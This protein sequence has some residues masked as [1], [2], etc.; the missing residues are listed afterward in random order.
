MF[1]PSCIIS[2][3]YIL[4][5]QVWT[6]VIKHSGK[7]KSRNIS[8]VSPLTGKVVQCAK[9]YSACNSQQGFNIFFALYTALAENINVYDQSP[10]PVERFY[11]HVDGP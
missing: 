4:L 10:P 11:V 9:N 1:G 3:G 6:Y 5:R 2:H 8:D 7:S